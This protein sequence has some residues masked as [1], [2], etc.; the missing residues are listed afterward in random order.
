MLCARPRPQVVPAGPMPLGDAASPGP[1]PVLCPQSHH[2][3]MSAATFTP[4]PA[5]GR[6]S[7]A[8]PLS[9]AHRHR[10]GDAV[11][12]AR[13]FVTTAFEV[14]VLGEYAEEAGVH[15]R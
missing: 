10:L 1:M 14:I 13:V 8:T 11:R 9:G 12:A 15:R 3:D 4:A 6:P 7:G 2:G 5:P